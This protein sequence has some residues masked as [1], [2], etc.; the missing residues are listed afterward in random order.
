MHSADGVDIAVGEDT[1]AAVA[2]PDV[3]GWEKEDGEDGD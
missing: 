3:E 2:A 1:G